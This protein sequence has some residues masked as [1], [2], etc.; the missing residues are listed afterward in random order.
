M[1]AA[2]NLPDPAFVKSFSFQKH[3]TPVVCRNHLLVS[4]A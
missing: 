4:A 1:N 3:G 2:K